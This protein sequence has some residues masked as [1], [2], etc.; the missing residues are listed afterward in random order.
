MGPTLDDV[1]Y[2]E[3]AFVIDIKNAVRYV[4]VDNKEQ[5]V[6]MKKGAGENRRPPGISTTD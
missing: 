5:H 4:K 2:S 1:G 6:D 3:F